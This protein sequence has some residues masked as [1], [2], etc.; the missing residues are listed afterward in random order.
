MSAKS[1]K[2]FFKSIKLPHPYLMPFVVMICTASV[3]LMYLILEEYYTNYTNL[4]KKLSSESER[5]ERAFSDVIKHT[6]FVMKVI[7][8]QIKSDHKNLDY[9]ESVINKYS[10]NPHLSN[11]LSWTVF[12]WFDKNGVKKVDAIS[13]TAVRQTHRSTRSYLWRVEKDPGRLYLGDDVFGFTSQRHIIPAA[14][15]A[16]DKD[17]KSIGYL[18]IGFDLLSLSNNLSQKLKDPDVTFALLDK[19]FNIITQYN[20]FSNNKENIINAKNV[21][22]LIEDKKIDFNT[23][24]HFSQSNLLLENNGV[25]IQRVPNYPFAI[26]LQYNNHNFIKSLRK[27]IIYRVSEVFILTL[28]SFIIIVFIYRREKILRDKAE[29]SKN[30][31]MKA[32][33]SKTDFLAYT[34]H[35]L[36]SPLSFIVSSSEMMSNKLFGPISLRYLEYIKNINQSG[37]EL[38][39]F[40]DDLLENMKLQKGNFD[41]KEE[42]VDVK[43]IISR[44]VKVNCV[45]FNDKMVVET[46]FQ[47]K[48]P[49]VLSDSKRLLQIFNNIISNAMKYSPDNSSLK[50]DAK[51]YK[52]EMFV[53]FH[54][55]GYG[56]SEEGLE[57]SMNEYEVAHNKKDINVKS[58]GLGLPLIK[59][60]MELMELKFFI[61][62]TLG[63]GTKITIVIP[64]H[65]I[66]RKRK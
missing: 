28:V 13:G 37:R 17:G 1:S 38:M 25:Y 61:D 66:Q 33:Q 50:I 18:T 22:K 52:G 7:L 3:M 40:I 31:A 26:Y 27:D 30:I 62:S 8:M 19:D 4:N 36:R 5:I 65:K 14:I 29:Y 23:L 45:N 20:N 51:M 59:S 16:A 15:G 49:M 24:T 57:K 63:R 53:H 34:A 48:L 55:K 54:D 56:M 44:S 58:V 2:G 32:L 47:S 46:Q 6:E 10:V 64:K 42:V 35:E 11:V 9:I 21:E 41:V 39:L 43:E 12:C 60:L